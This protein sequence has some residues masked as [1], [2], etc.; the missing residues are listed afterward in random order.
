VL[1]NLPP[2]VVDK[3]SPHQTGLSGAWA[4]IIAASI[5]VVAA[6]IALCGVWWQIRSAAKEARKNRLADAQLARQAQLVERMAEAI[7]VT[8]SMQDLVA[9]HPIQP[10]SEWSVDAR[11]EFKDQMQRGR[12]LSSMV[13]LLGATKSG[14]ALAHVVYLMNIVATDSRRSS[15]GSETPTLGGKSTYELQAKMIA[16]FD[17]DLSAEVKSTVEAEELAAARRPR[18]WRRLIAGVRASRPAHTSR[19]AGP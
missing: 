18:R 13:P 7:T 17:D 10:L 3:L 15:P 16:A 19:T 8:R 5:A 1:I 2:D 11:N 4:T 9:A 12:A 6:L 14:V